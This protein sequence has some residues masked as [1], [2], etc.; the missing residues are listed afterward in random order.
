VIASVN[1]TESSIHLPLGST[2]GALSSGDA[3][4]GDL[5]VKI[6]Y[7]V[8]RTIFVKMKEDFCFSQL[9]MA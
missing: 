3:E 5:V 6:L 9:D 7:P 1:G 8:A 2:T 4:N